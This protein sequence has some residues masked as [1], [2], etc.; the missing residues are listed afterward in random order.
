[1]KKALIIQEDMIIL[2]ILERLMNVYSYDCK[3]IRTLTDLDI[4]DQLNNFDIIISDILFDGIAPLD[5]IY[6]LQ[7]IITHKNLIILTNM[8]Q[9][10][11]ADQLLLVNKVNGFFRVP[12]DLDQI[13]K[14]IA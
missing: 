4:E 2:K 5:F 9:E 13:E 11:I 7:E 8:G 3:A 12:F 6:Q 1:M 10:K 14:M